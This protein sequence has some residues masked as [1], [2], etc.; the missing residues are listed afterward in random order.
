MP[1]NINAPYPTGVINPANLRVWAL[2]PAANAWDAAPVEVP[3]QGFWWLRLYFAYQRTG[4][5]GTLGYY[6]D[7][8]PYYALAGAPAAAREWFHG[9]LYVPGTLT[10]CQIV[11]STIQQEWISYCSTSADVETFISP[12]IHLGGCIERVRV[13]CRENSAFAP[14]RAS[15]VG[16]FYVEG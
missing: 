7:L 16:L 1:L 9:T 8:S 4:V 2:L 15:V 12:P 5:A 6:Y 3:C 10:P 11:H 14:G 13:F